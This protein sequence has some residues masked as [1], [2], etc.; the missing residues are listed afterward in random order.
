MV[1]DRAP[2]HA[3]RGTF[4]VVDNVSLNVD[5]T[6][7]TDGLDVVA[8]PVGPDY[9]QGMLVVKDGHN[10]DK[11]GADGADLNQN[12]KYISWADIAAALGLD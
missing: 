4:A 7:E 1:F 11:T 10:K 8:V 3:Y 5:G 2:P 6:G 9:P 12:F